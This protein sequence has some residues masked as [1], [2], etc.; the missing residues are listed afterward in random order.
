M[1]KKC[2]V[3]QKYSNFLSRVLNIVHLKFV[4]FYGD[5]SKNN[6]MIT[7]TNQYLLV[8]EQKASVTPQPK[9]HVSTE[10]M[11]FIPACR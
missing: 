10:I 1:T 4:V 6:L 11:N 2:R 7:S 3:E 5:G 8:R 9:K